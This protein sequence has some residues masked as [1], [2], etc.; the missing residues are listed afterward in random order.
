MESMNFSQTQ[1]CISLEENKQLLLGN[2]QSISCLHFYLK[3]AT[4]SMMKS[5]TG[6]WL[7]TPHK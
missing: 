2:S 7:T 4:A 3:Q 1:T 5:Q 6:I